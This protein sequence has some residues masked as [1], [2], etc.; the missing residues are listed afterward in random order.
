MR[1]VT[2]VAARI[3]SGLS[4][5]KAGV[6]ETKGPLARQ[7]GGLG[8][9]TRWGVSPLRCARPW[10]GDGAGRTTEPMAAASGGAAAERAR[11][12]TFARGGGCSRKFEHEGC[13]LGGR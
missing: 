13:T 7:R 12:G 5:G 11:D 10:E 8:A 2:R 4:Y 6:D 1:A 9:E 3:R